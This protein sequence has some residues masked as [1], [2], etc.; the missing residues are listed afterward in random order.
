MYKG[1]DNTI[2]TGIIWD[3]IVVQGKNGIDNK[4]LEFT[5]EEPVNVGMS[6]ECFNFI[7]YLRYEIN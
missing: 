2:N 5:K 1:T 6:S 3:D 7:L 4:V